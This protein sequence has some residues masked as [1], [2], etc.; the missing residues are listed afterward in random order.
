ML[1]LK[2]KIGKCRAQDFL[3][4]FFCCGTRSLT[5]GLHHQPFCE[6]FFQAR[7]HDLFAQIGFESLSS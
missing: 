4:F 5:Q 7:S 6:G 2:K 3:F 1:G